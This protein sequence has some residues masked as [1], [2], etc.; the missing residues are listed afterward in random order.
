M[1]TDRVRCGLAGCVAWNRGQKP[2]PRR[3]TIWAHLLTD[4]FSSQSLGFLITK[5]GWW[6]TLESCRRI[7][8]IRERKH[9]TYLAQ[10]TQQALNKVQLFCF[11]LRF[12]L[13]VVSQK[14]SKHCIIHLVS[15]TYKASRPYLQNNILNPAGQ[16]TYQNG[17]NVG[18][19]N[20]NADEAVEHRNSLLP[21]GTTALEDCG[22]LQN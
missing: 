8:Q 22:V 10:G 7:K 11:H 3:Q 4:V 17:Q 19:V 21:H 5:W 14:F 9:V 2:R 1:V 20:R 15:S 16:H 12:Y 13:R 6:L 18:T